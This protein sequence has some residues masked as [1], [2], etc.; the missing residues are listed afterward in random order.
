MTRTCMQ[1]AGHIFPKFAEFINML[2]M[3]I[4]GKPSDH[5]LKQMQKKARMLGNVTVV[6]HD[7][8]TGIDRFFSR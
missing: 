5:L 3:D 4:Y 1:A 2:T 6:V 7:L 8:E